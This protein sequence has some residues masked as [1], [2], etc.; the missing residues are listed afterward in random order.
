M[1]Y[2]LGCLL[3]M[4]QVKPVSADQR[5]EYTIYR[6][7]TPISV[8]GQLDELVWVTAPDVG[9]FV[10]PGYESG[11]KEQTMAKALWDD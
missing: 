7:S 2:L 5:P 8:D 3:V 1:T 4:A 6:V 9:A 10:F 11:N